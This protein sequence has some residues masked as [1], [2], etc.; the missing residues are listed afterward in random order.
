MLKV[1]LTGGIATGKSTVAK[2]F[3]ELGAHLVDT[4][5]LARQAVAP[6]SPALAEIQAAFG[7][8]VLGPDGGLDRRGL[9][10]RVFG[11]ERARARLNA[12]VHPRVGELV[13]AE[14][15]RLEDLDPGGVVLIDVPLLF[16]TNWRGR[17]AAVV[18]VYAPA[19]SQVE[20]LMARDKVSRQ[21]ALTALT[22]QMD[23][24]EKRRLAQFV[25]DN[26]GGMEETQTQVEAVWSQLSAMAETDP[27]RKLTDPN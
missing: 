16:E 13:D 5:Q 22:A 18:L 2:M 25:V 9:R 14:L 4:D 24:E 20:R 11:D 10:E 19:A 12:I 3:V 8:G 17:Y 21:G 1:G 15:R 7:P 26:S 6:G 27:S 23:I